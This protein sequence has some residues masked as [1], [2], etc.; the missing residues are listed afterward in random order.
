LAEA[1]LE[2]KEVPLAEE[3]FKNVLAINPKQDDALV[4]LGLLEYQRYHTSFT[5]S[6]LL[7]PPWGWQPDVKPLQRKL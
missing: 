5:T 6:L 4:Q 2:A 3:M 1:Y 7:L